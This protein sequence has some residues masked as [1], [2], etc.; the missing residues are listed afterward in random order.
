MP[1]SKT[2]GGIVS[3]SRRAWTSPASTPPDLDREHQLGA[4]PSAGGVDAGA[5]PSA[6]GAVGI[7]TGAWN[8]P[9]SAVSSA[10]KVSNS[11]SR[12]GRSID[13]GAAQPNAH[14]TSHGGKKTLRS[15]TI[16]PLV[17]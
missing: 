2:P 15:G 4:G 16:L 13:L 14:A 10:H 17:G 12:N 8:S 1:T 7:G 11:P 3:S 9:R 6:V 5:E